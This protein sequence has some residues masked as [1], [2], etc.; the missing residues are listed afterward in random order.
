MA[1]RADHLARTLITRLGNLEERFTEDRRGEPDRRQRIEMVEKI[2]AVELG[3]TDSAT[4]ALIEAAVPHSK[5]AR[6][7]LD[8]ELVEFAEFLRER[9]RAQLSEQR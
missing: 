3:I 6:Q 1:D 9:L 4:S 7:G 8:R 5:A 2:L